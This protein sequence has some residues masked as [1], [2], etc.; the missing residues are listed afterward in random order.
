MSYIKGISIDKDLLYELYVIEGYSQRDIA[1]KLG[2][3]QSTIRR[4]M[5]KYNITPRGNSESRHTLKYK[6]KESINAERYRKE[7]TKV[8]KKICANCNKEFIVLG[9]DKKNKKYCSKKCELENRKSKKNIFCQ[10]CGEEIKFKNRIYD[11][12]YCDECYKRLRESGKYG[13]YNKVETEC[14]YCHKKIFVIKSRFIKYEYVYCNKECMAKHYAEIYT[15]K[16]SPTWKGGKSHHYIGNFYH[17]RKLARKRDNYRCALCGI[18]EN[19]YNKEMSVHH[20][21]S[22]RSFENKEEANKLDN[23]ISL[24]E[25]CHR[26]VHSNKNVNK[27]F[28]EN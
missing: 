13:R 15:G 27:I 2:V 1:T 3:S 21:K 18:S 17:Q 22:Y 10:N 9:C 5:E 16:N 6:E 14:G 7:Y 24:C 25:N 26:F 8:Y 23:L 20:I 4:N 12:K 19:E 28:I 11:R